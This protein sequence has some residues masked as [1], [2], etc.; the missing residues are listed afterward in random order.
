MSA[1]REELIEIINRLNDEQTQQV[2]Q[3]VKTMTETPL[4]PDYDEAKDPA[5]GLLAEFSDAFPQDLSENHE[6]YLYTDLDVEE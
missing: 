5:I 1:L 3:I 2:L 4:K 6:A